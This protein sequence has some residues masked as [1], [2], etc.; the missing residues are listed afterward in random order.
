MSLNFIIQIWKENDMY[1]AYSPLID[2]SSCGNTLEEA[3]KNLYEAIE[4]F[5][6]EAKQRNVLKDILKEAGFKQLKNN[7]ESPSFLSFENAQ[8]SI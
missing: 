8:I 7:W 4:C 2:L 1:V 3:K 5:I 6:E